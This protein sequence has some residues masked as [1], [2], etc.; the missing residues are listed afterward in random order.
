MLENCDVDRTD[1]N[2]DDNSQR[3]L[4]YSDYNDNEVEGDQHPNI[5]ESLAP[6]FT[7]EEWESGFLL[8]LRSDFFMPHDALSYVSSSVHE[9]HKRKLN[10]LKVNVYF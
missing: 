3:N 10:Y 1:Y 8:R 9:F 6:T 4:N 5:I 7:D 2:S